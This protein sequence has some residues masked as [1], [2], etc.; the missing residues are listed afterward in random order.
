MST[1]YT[2]SVTIIIP[3][4]TSSA[5]Y[6]EN[7]LKSIFLQDYP[8]DSVEVIVVDNE[9]KDNT[10]VM[11]K[12]YGAKTINVLGSPPQVCEQRNVGA[13]RGIGEYFYF[14]DHDMEFSPRLLQ[15]FKSAVNDGDGKSIGAW[16]VPEHI[17]A[18]NWLWGKVRNFERQ[19][20]NTTVIDAAR[21]IKREVFFATEQFDLELSGGPAD[22]DLDNQLKEIEVKFDIIDSGVYHHEEEMS[23]IKYLRKKG[24]YI[25]G[26][27]YYKEKW[28]KRNKLIYN[29]VVVNQF[30]PFYR[31]IGVFFENGKWKKVF[32][33]IHFF[34][35]MFMLRGIVG[36]MYVFNKMYSFLISK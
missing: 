31:I 2:P 13:N 24:G 10:L 35:L 12:K 14:L 4:Y 26:A 15:S 27:T 20:Y 6:I 34:I 1:K 22:W 30:S 25:Q 3:T 33:Q 21:I 11:A 29:G 32:L 5:I 7:T 17:C 36:T 9:S 8:S 23:L 16:Y 28:K 19:F 18:N